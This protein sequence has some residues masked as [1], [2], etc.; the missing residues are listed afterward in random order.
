MKRQALSEYR[1]MRAD[2]LAI[3]KGNIADIDEGNVTVKKSMI[4]NERWDRTS[5]DVK[6]ARDRNAK[7]YAISFKE[8]EKI[9]IPNLMSFSFMKDAWRRSRDAAILYRARL[10]AEKKRRRGEVLEASCE[11]LKSI[12][13]L[14]ETR[15][16]CHIRVIRLPYTYDVSAHI[17]DVDS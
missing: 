14:D 6:M 11:E 5:E 1:G 3:R 10:I 9:E 15:V 8:A 4:V 7:K 17:V 2:P 12:R 13:F 16:R